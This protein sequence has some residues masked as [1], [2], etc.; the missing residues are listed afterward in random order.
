MEKF[1]NFW[2]H[3]NVLIIEVLVGTILVLILFFVFQYTFGKKASEAEASNGG[4]L[5]PDLEEALKK[6]IA[7]APAPA[8]APAVAPSGAAASAN[9]A[10]LEKL[11]RDLAEKEKLLA[12]AKEQA[13][14]ATA[15]PAAPAAPAVDTSA[16]DSKIKDL[17]AR[18]A[19]YEI[20]SE[21]IADLSFYKEE[22]AK[23]QTQIAA[24]NGG[25]VPATAVAPEANR[26]APAVINVDTAAPAP[27]APE[28]VVAPVAPAPEPAVAAVDTG[29]GVSAA[30][31]TGDPAP[32]A[33]VGDA[34]NI[35]EE[36]LMKEFAAAVAE[37]KSATGGTDAAS[38]APAVDAPPPPTA[39]ADDS[40]LMNQF[41]NFVK[42]G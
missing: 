42:K 32:A 8:A 29:V 13:A 16:L 19:E 21:D 7:T 26:E 24:L 30:A 25:A 23:L 14:K 5:S 22:N 18:L 36:E 35:S 41:E 38:G 1:L 3:Y 10:E 15:A 27:A 12:Q 40:Q 39:S 4:G 6:I 37:Q 9:S 31:T 33:P 2:T 20:I 28:P 17:E 11:K 34:V